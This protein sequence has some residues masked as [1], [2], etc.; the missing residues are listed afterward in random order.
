[1]QVA[2][3]ENTQ[4]YIETDSITYKGTDVFFIKRSLYA[5]PDEVGAIANV[6]SDSINCLTGVRATYRMIGFNVCLTDKTKK[7]ESV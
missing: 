2:S 3:S 4:T 5:F 1:M 6:S 7:L